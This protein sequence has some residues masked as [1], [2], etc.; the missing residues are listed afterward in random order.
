MENKRENV[1]MLYKKILPVLILLALASCAA[2]VWLLNESQLSDILA[3]DGKLD[4]S[5]WDGE[6]VLFL[7]GDWDFYWNRFLDAEDLSQNPLPD[8][9]A[10]V[11]SSWNKFTVDG[12]RLDGMGYATYRLHVTGAEAGVPLALRVLPFS[13]AYELYLDDALIAS[14]GRVSTSAEGFIPQY[15]IQT[16]TFTPDSGVFDLIL[17][18][19]NFVYAR[20]GAWYTIYFGNPEKITS[21]DRMIFGRDFFTM[22]CLLLISA[23]CVFLFCLRRDKVFLLFLALCA[24]FLARTLINGNYLYNILIPSLG[25]STVIR[26]DYIT[27]YFLPWL[28]LCLYRYVYPEEIPLRPVQLLLL[29]AAVITTL[30]LAVPVHIFTRFIYVAELVAAVTGVYGITKMII[31]AVKRKPEAFYLF[32]GGCALTFCIVHDVLGENNLSGTGYV[33]YSTVGFLIMALCF[34]CMFSARYDRRTKENERMLLELNQADERERKLE[35][36]FLKSQIRPHFINNALNAI[37]SISRTDADKS[38]KLLIEFSKYIQ[39][40]YSVQNLDDKVPIENE[41]SFVRAYVTLEQARFADSLDVT[42]EVDDV[43]LKVPPLTLQPLVE[44]AIIHGVM[45]KKG[46]GHV[47]IYVKDCGDFVK[48]GVWDDGVGIDP[49]LAA[50]LLSEKHTCMGIGIQNINLRMKRLYHTGLYLENRPEG[51]TNAY[52]VVPKEGEAC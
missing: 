51:G 35:L 28:C 21:I 40:C 46:D 22:S 14:S 18:I 45:G 1:V 7:S 31:L 41:L 17:H 3:R 52:I 27:L 15:K 37:I 43:F 47:L 13:T 50:A 16:V 30:T 39:N 49:G 38:R 9:K 4:V 36:Q 2:L 26:T 8:L 6:T 29:Y 32:A 34:Q 23:Y 5:G 12:K 11:P 42:Y 48:V 33:E 44:N 19:S 20:G 10:K 24:V 25:F